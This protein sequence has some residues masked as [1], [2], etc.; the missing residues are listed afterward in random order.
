MSAGPRFEILERAGSGSFAEVWKARDAKSSALVALKIARDEG[1]RRWL[2]REAAQASLALSPFLPELIDVGWLLVEGTS[3]WMVEDS[4]ASKG[5]CCIALRWTPGEP[6][7]SALRSRASA[8][9]RRDLALAVARDVGEALSDLHA[10]GQ[11]HGDIKPE[12]LI[13]DREGRVHVIDLGLSSASQDQEIEGA[14]PRY[15]ARGDVDLGNARARDLIALGA[16]LAEIIDEGVRGDSVP[17]AAARRAVLVEPL[18]TICAALLAPQPAARPSAAWVADAAS[19]AMVGEGAGSAADVERMIERNVRQVRATYLRL[20]RTE[21]ASS[22][23]TR[24]DPATWLADAVAKNLRAR[25]IAGESGERGGDLLGPMDAQQT[26]RWLTALV[27]S[28]AAG[29]SVASILRLGESAAAVAMTALARRVAPRVWT[30]LDLENALSAGPLAVRSGAGTAPMQW[31]VPLDSGRATEVALALVRVP[32]DP[33]AI[34]VVERTPDAPVVL[35]LA[36]V[37]ALTLRGEYG[38][39]RNLVLRGIAL[40]APLV[41]P[42]AADVLRR[43]G[44]FELAAGRA[45]AAID[46]G[47]DPDGVARAT[48]A[49][50]A[51]EGS[52]VEE[53]ANLLRGAEPAAAICEVQALVAVAEGDTRRAFAAVAEGE[54]FATTPE[55][56]ARL[57][58]MKAY[59]SHGHDPEAARHALSLAADHAVRAGAIVEEASYLTGLA[60]AAADCGDIALA[61]SSSRRGALLSELLEKPSLVA[62]ARLAGAV[63]NVTVGAH[64]DAVRLADE[65]IAWAR[66]ASDVHAEIHAEWVIA[67]A[68]PRGSERA[69]AAARRASLL[70]SASLPSD[71]LRAES[72]LLLHEGAT[73]AKARVRELDGVALDDGPA[74]GGAKLEWWGARA[75]DLSLRMARGEAS[76]PDE[77]N[78]AALV[79]SR[80]AALSHARAEVG[81]R[82]PALAAG[83]DLAARIG[84]GEMTRRLQSA[85]AAEASELLKRLPPELSDA[86]RMLPWVVRG[87]ISK[88]P[89]I[90][91]D[92]SRELESIVRSLSEREKLS[93]LLAHVVDSLVLWTGVERGL[94][95]LRAPDGRLVPRAA[96]NLERADLRGEQLALSQTLALRALELREPI[97]AT[98]AAGDVES[99]HRSAV[100]LK[101]R[102][103]LAV[104]LIAGGEALGVV[105]L[106]DRIRRG[107]FG[108]RELG[109]VRT[110]ASL[111]ALAIADARAQALY[112]RAARRA[113]RA[114][115]KLADVLAQREAALDVAERELATVRGSRTRFSY[116]ELVGASETMLTMLQMV[117][118]VTATSVPVLVIGESG[119]GKE[120]IVRAIH[121][122]GPRSQGP[123]VSENCGALPEGLLESALFGHVRGAFT[124]ADRTRSGLFEVADGGTLFLDEIGE[125]SLATQTKLLRVLEDGMVRPV[126][127]D[128]TRRVDVRIVGATHRDLAAMVKNKQF[129][130]DLFFRLNVI[131]I[132][133]PPLRERSGDIPLIVRQMLRKHGGGKEFGVTRA[134]MAR[135]SAYHWPGNVRQLENEVRRTIVLSDGTIDCEHLSPEIVAAAERTEVGLDLRSRVDMLEADLVRQALERTRGNQTQAAKILGLSRF[136]LQKMITRLGIRTTS[137]RAEP[138]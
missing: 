21:I 119:S 91:P 120:L 95:L 72:R 125:L 126:G 44:D 33:S 16:V 4:A 102:S 66:M 7:A 92:Q 56:L 68:S 67:D 75:A 105:Y 97:V 78:A 130:E 65:A 80:L 32:A 132:R 137:V 61:L 70:A 81:A 2:A 84:D 50:M 42:V 14:S 20:R 46:R 104:P 71:R 9:S 113:S 45:R 19:A 88:E 112:R 122:N 100:A 136:G 124:G 96:R 108:A 24:G 23:G 98:D 83:V 25:S 57:A 55:A 109:W 127:S 118:R 90:D 131:A 59:V 52:R 117:D 39:A 93:D 26:A 134:A 6:L 99:F 128:R 28:S 103:V 34:E 35:L 135:L 36:A 133:V 17:I 64:H 101:L 73:F 107:A 87:A 51:L 30:S 8:S 129:R 111:A 5:A 13:V 115:R 54:A 47:I 40:A 11:A 110:I 41:D 53:A 106:D 49:R 38:R 86:A 43:A 69:I 79:L 37:R 123:F 27:G 10:V 63:A 138:D 18:Q 121:S 114:S 1:A 74:S 3:A 62:R 12:N 15:L 31:G 85:L 116:D 48:L 77:G 82:G 22:V 29:W 60:G 58:G 94:L 89:G 76:I